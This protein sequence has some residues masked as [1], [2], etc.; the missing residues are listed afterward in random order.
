LAPVYEYS[1]ISLE[2][3]SLP[4]APALLFGSILD[5]WI[6]LVSGGLKRGPMNL[7]G[8]GKLNRFFGVEW[9]RV[10]SGEQRKRVLRE[11]T[12]IGGKM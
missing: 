7:P 1:R 5:L 4:P 11:N 2:I 3:I 6:C 8:E 9:E 12:S 10:G